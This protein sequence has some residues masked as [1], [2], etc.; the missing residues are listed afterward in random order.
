MRFAINTL[1]IGNKTGL[2]NIN[3]L[4]ILSALFILFFKLFNVI[5]LTKENT[6]NGNRIIH[7]III[8]IKPG[9]GP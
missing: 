1:A 4:S 7:E 6:Q 9:P 3:I 5:N 8:E 2:K